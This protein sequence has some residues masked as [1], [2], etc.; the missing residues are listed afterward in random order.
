LALVE[1]HPAGIA[2]EVGI[3]ASFADS[4]TNQRLLGAAR[5]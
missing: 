1:R 4:A 3:S 2:L 5:A